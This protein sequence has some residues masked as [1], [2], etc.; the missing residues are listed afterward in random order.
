MITAQEA[1]KQSEY[2]TNALISIELKKIE[3]L[4]GNAVVAGGFHISQDG[5]LSQACRNRLESLGY[6]V[7]TGSQYNEPWYCIKW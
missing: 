3:E 1:R 6:K 2:N 5:T 7:E 4:I